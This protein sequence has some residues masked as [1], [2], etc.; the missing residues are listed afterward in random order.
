MDEKQL[1][2]YSGGHVVPLEH[3]NYYSCVCGCV[4]VYMCMHAY[5]PVCLFVLY[6]HTYMSAHIKL[7]M[8]IVLIQFWISNN[9]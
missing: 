8:V 2:W 7:F 3:K 6:K 1:P 5:V 4:G 9:D